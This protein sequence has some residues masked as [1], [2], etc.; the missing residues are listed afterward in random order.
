MSNRLKIIAAVLIVIAVGIGMSVLVTLPHWWL[1][2]GNAEAHVGS[3]QIGIVTVYKS[4][5]GNLLFHIQED[6]VEDHY[7]FYPSEGKIGIPNSGQFIPFP[8]ITPFLA[9]SKDDQPAVA[10]SDDRIKVETD[11]N[12]VVNGDRL[13]FNTSYGRRIRADLSSY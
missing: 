12:I 7:V 4:T 9:F 1:R 2:V 6:S 13:E 10:F 11:M 3:G 5:D 8:P